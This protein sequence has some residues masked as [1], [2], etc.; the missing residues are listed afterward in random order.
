[1][2]QNSIKSHEIP[3]KAIDYSQVSFLGFSNQYSYHQKKNTDLNPDK[4][5]INYQ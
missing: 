3:A 4:T 1:M 5:F 2:S